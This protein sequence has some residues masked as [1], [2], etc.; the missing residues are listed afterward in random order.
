MSVVSF[1]VASSH[2]FR[3]M[4]RTERDDRVKG[5]RK[6]ISRGRKSGVRESADGR[7]GGGRKVREGKEK[8]VTHTPI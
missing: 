8:K 3:E 7:E 5:G 4:E 6:R 1:I 2:S